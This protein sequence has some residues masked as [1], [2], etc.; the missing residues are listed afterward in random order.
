MD[1]FMDHLVEQSGVA[2][3]TIRHWISLGL[4]PRPKGAGLGAVYGRD[5]LLRVWVV[6]ALRREGMRLEDIKTL[7]ATMTPQ[8]MGKYKPKP[9]AAGP[10]EGAATVP[11]L[12]STVPPRLGTAANDETR[13]AT[14]DAAMPG[15][16]YAVVPLLP[17]L[18]LMLDEEAASIVRRAAVEIIERYGAG[19]GAS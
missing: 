2:A 17:G 13:L 7:L 3:R 6:A 1:L 8:Q 16:R 5:H 19:A 11:G 18:I 14:K 15:R 4:L 12:D 9:P 10:A